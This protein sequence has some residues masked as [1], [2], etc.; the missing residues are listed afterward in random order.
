MK[1]P[2]PIQNLYA[3]L[4]DRRMLSIA[5]ALVA[6]IIAVPFLLGGS[7]EEEI[8]PPPPSVTAEAP[9]EG[10]EQL[11]PV[12]LAEVPGLR[13]FR[14]RL[15]G[16]DSHNPFKFA[17]PKQETVGDGGGGAGTQAGADTGTSTDTGTD[18]GTVID[19]PDTSGS[20]DT[21]GDVTV[22]T[23]PGTDTGGSPDDSGIVELVTYRIDVRVGPVGD[24]KV[25]K[26]VK[27]LDF[28]PDFRHPLVEY[29]DADNAGNRVVFIVNPA[30]AAI[31]GEWQCVRSQ[32]Q[33]Q[34][35]VMG[36]NDDMYFLF[37]DQKWR[38]QVKDIV[39][40]REPYDPDAPQVPGDDGGDDS[41]DGV[42]QRDL[43]DF[44]G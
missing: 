37:D 11:D 22:P 31:K 29:V 2:T 18:D 14:E 7:G 34:Y 13:D 36:V 43:G 25:V 23:D 6:A 32:K 1:V 28:L 33:C 16:Y 5:I 15:A 42:S 30:A 10:S 38:L 35:L 4:R 44:F 17:G 19:V 24:T 9:F 12:V 8:P 40:H 3:D 26:D 27:N 20:T 41:D 21:G 39:E